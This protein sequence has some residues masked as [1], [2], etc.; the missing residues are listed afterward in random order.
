MVRPRVIIAD[1]DIEYIIP[2]QMKFAEEYGDK[3]DLETVSS[4]DFFCSLFSIPQSAEILIVSEELFDASLLKHNI[5]NVFLMTEQPN[6]AP[7]NANNVTC[8]DKYTSIKEIFNAVIGKSGLAPKVHVNKST[9]T[10]YVCSASGGTGK[11]TVAMAIGA[12]LSKQYKRVLYINA[13]HLQSFQRVLKNGSAVTSPDVYAKLISGR[14]N[15]YENI[16]HVIRNEGLFSYIPPFKAALISL[17]I[18]FSVYKNIISSAKESRDYDYILID[19][20][21]PFDESNVELLNLADKVIVVTEQSPASV[22]ATDTFVAN[23]NGVTPE[24]YIFVCNKYDEGLENALTSQPSGLRFTVNDYIARIPDF[25]K[26][27][28]FD[29]ADDR[30]IGRVAFLLL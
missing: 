25:D 3:I 14:G 12:A 20:N 19:S 29:L 15:V 8:L 2:L 4:R 10:V 1:S 13:S 22:F 21:A 5:G 30:G 6:Y 27:T 28:L 18:P 26:Y 17:E 7:V 9:Q 23:L 24:T 11:T 16:K